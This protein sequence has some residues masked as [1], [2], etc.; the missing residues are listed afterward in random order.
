MLALLVALVVLASPQDHGLRAGVGRVDVTPEPPIRLAGYASRTSEAGA[1]EQRLFAKAL[2][3]AQGDGKPVIVVTLDSTGITAAIRERVVDALRETGVAGERIA[4]CVT[5]SHNAPMLTG[6]IPNMFGMPVPADQQARIDAHTA[7]VVDGMARAMREA[8]ADLRPALVDHARGRAGF[9]RNRRTA[10]GPVDHDVPLL[11]VRGADGSLRA[12]LVLYACHCT[13]LGGD[14]NMVC[15][16]WA[17]Y[18]QQAVEEVHDGCI[19]M[20]AIGCGADANPE[21]R[22]N[23]ALAQQHGRTLAGE[24]ERL[25]RGPFLPIHGPIDARFDSIDLA[26]ARTPS[27]EELLARVAQG[28][29]TGYHARVQLA[30]LDRGEALRTSL[31]MPVQSFVLGDELAMVFLGGEVV[32]DY[33]LRLRREFDRDRLWV[34]GYANDVSAYIPSER[35]LREGGYEGGGAMIWYD[36]PTAFAP[37]LEERIVARVHAQVPD[38]F[39]PYGGLDPTRTEEVPARS[40][41][42]ARASLQVRD[43]LRVELAACEPAIESPAA[44]DFAADGSVLVCEMRDYPTVGGVTG[45]VTRLRDRDGD[46]RYE[47]V[48]RFLDDVKLPSG[49][50]AHGTGAYV[51]AGPDVL[52]AEDRDGDGRAE[53]RTVVLTGFADHNEQ[54]LVNSPTR[55]LDGRIVFACGLFGGVVGDPART[56]RVDVRG[57]DFAWD[58]A[59][60]AIEILTGQTQQGRTRNDFDEWFGCD[61]GT[62]A[63]HYAL[64]ARDV[65]RNPHHAARTARMPVAVGDD[66]NRMFAISAPIARYNDLQLAG[67]TTSA[68]GLGVLRDPLLGDDLLDDLFVCEPVAN[69]VRRLDL[70]REGHDYRGARAPGEEA[71][72]F[73][74]STDPWF[75]PVQALTGPDGALWVVDMARFLIEHPRW[76]PQDRLDAIDARAGDRLGRIWRVVPRDRTTRSV[77]DLTPLD[78]KALAEQI[79]SPNG[80]VRDLAHELL[81]HRPGDEVMAAL[82]SLDL[83]STS[84][85]T[86]APLLALFEST[87]RIEMRDV[88]AAMVQDDP[89]VRR[90]GLRLARRR[91]EKEPILGDAIYALVDD[92]DVMVRAEAAIALGDWEHERGGEALAHFLSRADPNDA[93]LVDAVLSSALPHLGALIDAVLE[94]DEPRR[95]GWLDPLL[96]CLVAQDERG[97]A[98]DV[99]KALWRPGAAVD[100]LQRL[101][102]ALALAP[103][104]AGDAALAAAATDARSALTDANAPAE[105]RIAAAELL[106]AVDGP[107]DGELLIAA[108][109]DDADESLQQAALRGLSRARRD[110]TPRLLDRWVDASPA[111]RDSLFD[112]LVRNANGALALLERASADRSFA[113]GLSAARQQVLRVHDDESVR[114]RATEVLARPSPRAEVVVRYREVETLHGDV[115][116]GRDVFARACATC[117]LLDG[118][119]R[120]IGP[121]LA[122]LSDR[123]TGFLLDAILDPNKG[124]RDDFTMFAITTHDAISYYGRIAT[125]DATH[126]TI[127]GVDGVQHVLARAALRSQ[128]NTGLSLMPEGLETQLDLAA[129]SDLFAFLR[130]ERRVR[131]EFPG[132]TPAVIAPAADG[133]LALLATNCE[134]FGTSIVLEPEFMN[135][136]YWHSAGDEA[137]WTVELATAGRFTVELDCACAPDSAGNAFVLEGG[138]AP[139]RGTIASTGGWSRYVTVALGELE[140]PAG[141]SRLTVRPTGELRGALM[142]LRGLRLVTR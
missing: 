72:E 40:P 98:R 26:F 57:H 107:G 106:G 18:A 8:L 60:G 52:L 49:V 68:C 73:L 134:I 58:P 115:G 59:S 47:T 118:V 15:G 32:V 22:G 133:S 88:I 42:R 123:S 9:A 56:E 141:R 28:G 135:L 109:A 137:V 70:V 43:G 131:R 53:T 100:R 111:L 85:H 4:M 13:T 1:V 44:I 114:R 90:Y 67:R 83:K 37:G 62:L 23:L 87:G 11:R 25:L 71:R 69:A 48:E 103:L 95:T 21:P 16:D 117:H 20:C 81:R 142:D 94:F 6:T 122:A 86:L 126:V 55:A 112:L 82:R 132:N 102:V 80:T 105:C 61:S 64:D 46:G 2:A 119:G 54:A 31:P 91:L 17:G 39:V 19:A 34:V 121:D 128:R 76:V 113:A 138:A 5:H 127:V 51:C 110:V 125:S 75:R 136:G 84:S 12:L 66:P 89:R 93:R 7:R 45:R 35:I 108:L 92:E 77:P 78:T 139:L 27:R 129:M 104:L 65:A 124:V 38:T 10:G 24:I 33:S 63:W 50:L 36:Q 116:R 96:P 97:L 29:G 3:L 14:S 79:K 30:R 101:R 130:Q 140:L 99:V 74:A 41:E 120:A